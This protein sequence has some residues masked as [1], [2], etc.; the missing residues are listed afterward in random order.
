MNMCHM[1]LASR[2]VS[3]LHVGH[4]LSFR[5][6]LLRA[7]YSRCLRHKSVLFN[8]VRNDNHKTLA[9]LT[10]T[11]ASQSSWCNYFNYR[12]FSIFT[13]T[14]EIIAYG[15]VFASLANVPQSGRHDTCNSRSKNDSFVARPYDLR[16]ISCLKVN[17]YL[18]LIC[19]ESA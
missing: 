17:F 10:W 12:W 16:C 3:A 5:S 6:P 13:R 14:T 18:F 11:V 19:S 2:S 9:K 4:Q 7:V 8:H 15:R 1:H